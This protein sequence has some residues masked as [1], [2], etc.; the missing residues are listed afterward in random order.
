MDL[1]TWIVENLNTGA[2]YSM[3]FLF[4]LSIDYA[5]IT[6]RGNFERVLKFKNIIKKS[7]LLVFLLS[8]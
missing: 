7:N 1:K 8:L 2:G 5:Q 3:W 4:I 6:V